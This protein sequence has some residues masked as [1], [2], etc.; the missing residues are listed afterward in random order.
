MR[1]ASD[2]PSS[3][4][5]GTGDDTDHDGSGLGSTG[6]ADF[7]SP[8]RIGLDSVVARPSSYHTLFTDVPV[9]PVPYRIVLE[10][11]IGCYSLVDC[12]SIGQSSTWWK[13]GWVNGLPQCSSAGVPAWISFDQ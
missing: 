8:P 13:C 2:V 5:K 1:P 9:P 11:C 10:Y 6:Y 4:V 3:V 12:A 7:S